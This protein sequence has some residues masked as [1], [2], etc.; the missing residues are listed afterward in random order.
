VYY[1]AKA[2]VKYSSDQSTNLIDHSIGV[3]QGD[4][5]A[6]Y[7]FVIVADYVMRVALADQTLGLKIANKVGTTT[8]ISRSLQNI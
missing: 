4:T 6:P 5:L 1:G 3:L 2:K 8:R 7:L